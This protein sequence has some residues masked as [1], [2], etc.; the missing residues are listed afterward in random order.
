M[1]R[2]LGI[3][4]IVETG[5]HKIDLPP[6]TR[7]LV[8]DDNPNEEL[9]LWGTQY[10]S[11]SVIAHLRTV[12][13]S[14]VQLIDAANIPTA[15]IVCRHIF[16]W[17]AHT[18]YMSRNT[19]NY[20]ERKEWGRAWHLHSLAMQGNRWVKDHGSKYEPALVTGDVPDPLGI[21]NIVS[22]YDEYRRQRQ[23]HADAKDSYG[24][25]SE[26]SHPNSACFLP[27][28]Q[29]VGW[30]VRFVAPSPDTS[31]LGEERC[32]IDLMM[33]LNVLL[34]LGREKVVRAQIVAILKELAALADKE[35][36]NR[37]V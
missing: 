18:C 17:A 37:T 1:P 33:F 3:L 15:F 23:G 8:A 4:P 35:G 21:A 9:V 28:Y 11:Y 32:L 5:L 19:K 2:K 26:H 10:Y 22:C 13:H 34:E 24:L 36:V 16:E 6:L 29:Y 14:L 12:L 30:E 25:L 7:P 20:V 27:Y 31:L